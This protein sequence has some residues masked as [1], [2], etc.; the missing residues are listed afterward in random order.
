ML[1]KVSGGVEGDVFERLSLSFL[2]PRDSSLVNLTRASRHY[3][4]SL[5]GFWNRFDTVY[6][7]SSSF[8]FIQVAKN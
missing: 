4:S 8:F 3:L 7:N 1:Y 2:N 5:N 6:T